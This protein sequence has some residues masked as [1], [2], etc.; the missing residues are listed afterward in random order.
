MK[1]TTGDSE[2]GVPTLTTRPPGRRDVGQGRPAGHR[3]DPE[4]C[5]ATMRNIRQNLFFAL[6]YNGLRV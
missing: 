6:A 2:G 3:E 1:R 5:R 4:A